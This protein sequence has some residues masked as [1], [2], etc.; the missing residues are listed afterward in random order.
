MKQK[1]LGTCI[2]SLFMILLAMSSFLVGF[3][4]NDLIN[5]K[6]EEHKNK[7]QIQIVPNSNQKHNNAEANTNQNLFCII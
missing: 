4:I 3:C 7:L 6:V 2:M 5:R 1:Q